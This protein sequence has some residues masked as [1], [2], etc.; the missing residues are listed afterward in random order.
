LI[1]AKFEEKKNSSEF[2]DI[3]RIDQSKIRR[4]EELIRVLRGICRTVKTILSESF[5][6]PAPIRAVSPKSVKQ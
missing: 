6:Q 1:R 2:F 3:R 4:Q 5:L